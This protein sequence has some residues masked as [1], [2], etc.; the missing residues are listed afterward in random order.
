ML[1][2]SAGSLAASGARRN[3]DLQGCPLTGDENTSA[4]FFEHAQ[5]SR[6]PAPDACLE[7]SPLSLRLGLAPEPRARRLGARADGE[8]EPQPRGRSHY[9]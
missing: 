7:R 2:P 3:R 5:V 6:L 4:G 8:A 9:Q 1:R